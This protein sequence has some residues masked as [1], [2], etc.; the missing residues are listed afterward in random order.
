MQREY[1]ATTSPYYF[2]YKNQK[3]S[4]NFFPPRSLVTNSMEHAFELQTAKSCGKISKLPP[5]GHHPL[6]YSY[7][8]KLNACPVTI[9]LIT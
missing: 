7:K 6:L 9:N 5:L 1:N 4:Y 8:L 2:S 3:S